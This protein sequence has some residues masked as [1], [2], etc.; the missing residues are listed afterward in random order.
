MCALTALVVEDEPDLR[1]ILLYHLGREGFDAKATDDGYEALRMARRQCFD[2]IL[3]DLL[4]VGLDGLS[5]CRQ[6]KAEPAS[7]GTHVIIVSAKVEEDDVLRGLAVGA[8]DYVRKP[9]RPREVIARVK[10]VLRRGRGASM[11]PAVERLEFPPLLLN[12]SA[13]EVTLWGKSL[14]LTQS[15]F[16]ILH[17]MMKSPGRVFTR[18]QLHSEFSECCAETGSR[19]IDVHVRA[20]R[21]KLADFATVVES[22]RGVGYRFVPAAGDGRAPDVESSPS[23]SVPSI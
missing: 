23:V 4:L 20:L 13:H 5:L 18:G 6:F 10:T 2:V 19:S 21:R 12:E 8:D 17:R 9:F 16:R 14:N 7:A 11:S 22:V 3:L 15:E 1:E